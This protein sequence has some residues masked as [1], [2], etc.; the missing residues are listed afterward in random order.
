MGKKDNNWNLQKTF[1]HL[2]AIIFLIFYEILAA[3][4]ILYKKIIILSNASKPLNSHIANDNKYF[5]YFKN[6]L[7]VLN[8]IHLSA[9]LPFVIVLL[10]QN[11]KG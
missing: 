7:E 3:L 5:S 2:G 9:H 8:N 4:L 6:C 10:Y 11:Y 1:Q